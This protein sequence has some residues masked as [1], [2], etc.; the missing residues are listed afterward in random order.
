M[1]NKLLVLLIIFLLYST[2]SLAIDNKKVLTFSDLHFELATIRFSND[3]VKKKR[4]TLNVQRTKAL[5]P[6]PLTTAGSACKA[7]NEPA[8]KV[9]ITASG[10]SGDIIEWFSSQTSSKILNKGSIY[11]PTISQTTT[12]Y[13][14]SHAGADTSIRVPVVASILVTP[15]SISL[16]SSPVRE[17]L[18]EGIPVS[19]T[20]DGGGDFFE[21]S[22]D[23][24]VVQPM[25]DNRIYTN[26][27]L[28]NGQVVSVK[29]RYGVTLDGSILENAWGSGALED[30]SLSATLSPA[31]LNGYINAVKIAPAEDKLVFGIAG[32]LDSNKSLLLFLDTKPGGFNISNYGSENNVIPSAKGFNYF[33]NNVST[34]DS[35]FQADY[36]LVLSSD[37]GGNNYYADIIELKNN[38]STKVRIGNASSGN[39]SAVMGVNNTN[40]GISDYERGF[41]IEILKS[42]MGYTSGDIKFFAFTTQDNT[43]ADFKITNSFLSPELNSSADY[44][45][46]GIDFNLKD[47]NP[48]V[49]SADALISCYAEASVRINLTEKPSVSTVGGDQFNCSLSSTAL[50]GN[51]PL[52]GV[53]EWFMKSGP[54]SVIFSNINLGSSTAAVS[55]AGTYEFSWIIS[56]G[57]CAKSTSTI[58]VT[59]NIIPITPSGTNQ[60]VCATSPIQTLTATSLAQI[61]ESIV[62]YDSLVGGNIVANPT[63]N[64]IGTTTYF[65]EAINSATLCVSESRAPVI[66]T[67]NITPD[68]PVSG[69][70]QAVC[71]SSPIQ[72][73]NATATVNNGETIV[74]YD[75][76]TGGNVVQ[77]PNLNLIG[78]VTYYAEAVNSVTACV[79][80]SRTAVTLTINIKPLIPVS[81]GNQTVCAT[82]PI[83]T[84]TATSTAQNGEL[85]VW[86]DSLI[87]GN[88][89]VN[90]TLS[91]IGAITYFA[92]SVNSTTLCTSESRTAVT[93]TINATPEKPISGSNQ[94]VCATSPIQT[95]TATAIVKSGD[96]VVWY[97]SLINGNV[98]IN[99]N[100]S[101]IGNVTYYA[102]SVNILNSCVSSDRTAV[103]L[104]IN[105]NPIVPVS[106]GNQTV[107]ATSPIETLTAKAL[108][109]AGESVIWYDALTGGNI[110]SNANLSSIGTITYYAQAVNNLTFCT[111]ESRTAVT[112]TIYSNP[113]E[114]VSVGNQNVCASLPI[115]ILTATATVLNGE[116]LIWYDSL[117]GGNLVE[118]PI[119][120][121]IGT[122]TYYAEARNNNS[123]C[124]SNSRTAVTLII[125]A[126]PDAPI[127]GGDQTEC[128]N[129]SLS[130]T[131]IATASGDSVKWYTAAIGGTIVTNPTKIGV[132]SITYYAESVV[133]NCVSLTRTAVTLTI[134]DVVAN[135]IGND[136]TVCSNGSSMQT[137]TAN[138]SGNTIKW[139]SELTGGVLITNPI[140]VGV[141]T[142]SYYAESSVGKCLSKSRTKITLTI[143]AIPA[144]PSANVTM[145]PSCSLSTGEITFTTQVGAEY[146]I[147]SGFQDSPI[148]SNVL[149]GNYTIL[150][151]YKNNSACDVQGAAITVKA[152]PQQIQFEINGNCEEKEYVLTA[153]SASNSYSQSDVSYQWK[154][155][156]GNSVGTNSNTLNVSSLITSTTEKEIFPLTYSLSISSPAT[157]CELTKIFIVETILC[158][159]QKGI[160]PDGN[161]SN[162]YF[163]L[164]LLNVKKL[165]IFDR[166]GIKVYSQFNY[167]NQ[168]KGQSSRGDDLPT[169]TYYYVIEFEKGESKTGWIYLLR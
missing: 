112:L 30:N 117:V 49:V 133:G 70:D 123:S 142:T 158:N 125:N 35:Y 161:G 14:Q 65:A 105:L 95:L 57:D 8:V 83:Q 75:A 2:K 16:I 120:S 108:V 38:N 9:F 40:A 79:S 34:F 157:G 4:K 12:F 52:V 164:R 62:W 88:T 21:F 93:L 47:P 54:G 41:E 119:L 90:P 124:T 126:R 134:V 145:Q 103:T 101:A 63:L 121:A 100:L 58:K 89:V 127:S 137:L 82:S 48:V 115:Q 116:S 146:S 18:C 76:L 151:R 113:M 136:Q 37:D 22:V 6:P 84:L 20:A 59:F 1:K 15:P 50:G 61:G 109:Q 106:G 87:G 51:I 148:F 66:L 160:S 131:L 168:W 149:P 129:G 23:G 169:A 36:C 53:G 74:W 166:Y 71:A 167:T 69:S 56:N 152:I 104:T 31:A 29:S 10:G 42:L 17:E 99:P 132:G 122:I 26:N 39:P 86:Y 91:L 135:P 80:V 102:E 162:E 140:H 46:G 141:G 139:Y 77:N 68:N 163:D 13:V 33:K 96:S 60:T 64:I 85:I 154:D 19:F 156:N 73:L 110:V 81:G 107:C 25:S 67:I 138:A 5:I 165:E 153:T 114:P 3:T 98:I 130:Q 147:G 72:T 159:I 144:I 28:T 7:I 143:T 43:L 24:I 97:D 128:T 45:S 155:N 44:G 32:R 27:T 94:T 118:N 11:A 111:S 150:V 92:E 55:I 78:T